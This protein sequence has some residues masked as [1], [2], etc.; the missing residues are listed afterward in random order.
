MTRENVF[1]NY[2]CLFTN[3]ISEQ[4]IRPSARSQAT[5]CYYENREKN[6][7]YLFLFGGIGKDKLNDLWICDL[8]NVLYI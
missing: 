7:N 3:Y 4:T 1:Q 2:C 6:Y 8:G 5:V